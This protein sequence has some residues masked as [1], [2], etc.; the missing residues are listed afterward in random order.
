MIDIKQTMEGD[1][2]ISTSDVAFVDTFRSTEQHKMDILTA[3]PGDYAESPL[4]GVALMNYINSED[5]GTL[6]YEIG[7]QMRQDGM[8]V[9]SVRL[10]NDGLTI[11]ARYEKDKN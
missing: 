2:D 7:K 6:K 10:D 11:D 1:I 8:T 3:A 5:I 4:T 9:T